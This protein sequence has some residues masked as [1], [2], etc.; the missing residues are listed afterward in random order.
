MKFIITIFTLFSF[1]F[2]GDYGIHVCDTVP[3]LNN[4]AIN[5]DKYNPWVNS[6][7]FK[8]EIIK[9]FK[10][11]SS[12]I[13]IFKGALTNNHIDYCNKSNSK[14]LINTISE[15]IYTDSLFDESYFVDVASMYC[16]PDFIIKLK[17]NSTKPNI[18]KK[19]KARI[20]K[21]INKAKSQ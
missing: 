21:I 19:V 3:E 4:N 9:Y 16:K 7:I 13:V 14:V 12:D 11:G 17:E 1:S 18:S 15:L 20:N 6:E 8:K 5:N 10:N 2:A